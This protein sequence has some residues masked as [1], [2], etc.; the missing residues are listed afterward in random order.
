M[1][2]NTHCSEIILP[3]GMLDS[4]TPFEKSMDQYKES[5]FHS[6]LLGDQLPLFNSF[7]LQN[8]HF[9]MVAPPV[10]F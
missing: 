8:W 6:I 5:S 2:A 9:Y 3:S 7:E 10:L 1:W 4:V